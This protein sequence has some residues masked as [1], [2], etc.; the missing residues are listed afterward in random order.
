MR[1]NVSDDKQSRR[2]GTN[3]RFRYFG[4]VITVPLFNL[5]RHLLVLVDN[6]LLI[7]FIYLHFNSSNYTYLSFSS[8]CL[9]AYLY[10]AIE[11]LVSSLLLTTD[12]FSFCSQEKKIVIVF[13]L[14]L[15]VP[16]WLLNKSDFFDY[17]LSGSCFKTNKKY[18]LVIKM[19]TS[20]IRK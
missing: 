12:R 9:S 14:F 18:V 20:K 8:N 10:L 15:T 6:H 2:L 19:V 13:Y 16:T 5:T 17:W 7:L 3:I 11:K 1:P 4:D